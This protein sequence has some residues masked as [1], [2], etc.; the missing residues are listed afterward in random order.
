MILGW[1]ENL[2]KD[3]IPPRN[4]WWSGELLD[5]WFEDVRARR[6]KKTSGRRSTYEEADD[7][8]SMGN[9]LADEARDKLIPR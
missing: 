9:Q 1:F 8:P 3:E 6:D 4:L 5:Q 7:S 2:P